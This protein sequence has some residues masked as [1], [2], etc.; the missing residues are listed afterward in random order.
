MNV[1]FFFHGVPAA[2]SE[3]GTT[4]DS[5]QRF[6]NVKNVA[7]NVR[8]SIEVSSTD[9]GYC[10]Y[11]SYL[12][13]NN[14]ADHTGRTGSYFGL[15]IRFDNEYC[16]DVENLFA[17][18][19]VAYNTQVCNQIVRQH[20][21]VTQ[22]IIANFLEKQTILQQICNTLLDKIGGL[23]FAPIAP[24]LI[25][26]GQLSAVSRF[27]LNE[28]NSSYFWQSLKNASQVLVSP[29]YTLRD[30]QI[31]SLNQQIEPERA[32]N[33]KLT[34]EN[35]KLK[36]QVENLIS[37]QTQTQQ[38]LSKLKQHKQ[39]L[40][41][42]N[43]QLKNDIEQLKSDLGKNKATRKVEQSVGQIKEPLEE[44]VSAIKKIIPSFRLP[45]EPIQQ[46]QYPQPSLNRK[47][48]M[49]LRD[50]FTFLILL[51]VIF[52]CVNQVWNIDFTEKAKPKTERTKKNKT[53][54][55]S[56]SYIII[57]GITTDSLT[58]AK[59]YSVRLINPPKENFYWRVDGFSKPDETK[60]LTN[61]TI[62]PLKDGSSINANEV[63][64]SCRLQRNDSILDKKSWYIKK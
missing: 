17:L 35:A 44:L 63:I 40:E 28:T 49:W 36:S 57:D 48:R 42:A 6:Y 19:D 38:E 39:Q 55:L 47:I 11:Y 3:W 27:N 51:L 12:R 29:N 46:P 34:E 14:F 22:Y 13:Y 20:G 52:L 50:I 15:T 23:T 2:F 53:A 60:N 4:K 7:E 56:G 16:K 41:Q 61:L 45:V 26:S 64:I 18:C 58:I 25:T 43:A 33:V 54:P 30:K 37:Q 10:T 1:E 8:F 62:H 31:A 59:D 9:N 21:N 5:M 32:K 24:T